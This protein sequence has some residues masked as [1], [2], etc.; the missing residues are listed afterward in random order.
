[1]TIMT[2]REYKDFDREARKEEYKHNVSYYDP[3]RGWVLDLDRKIN[4]EDLPIT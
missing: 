3:M 4:T 2:F 1:M